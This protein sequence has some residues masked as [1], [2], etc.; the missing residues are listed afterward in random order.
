MSE[1]MRVGRQ[2]RDAAAARLR[3]AYA[4][5]YLD[6]SELERR[7]EEV[8]AAKTDHAL[9]RVTSD[10]PRPEYKTPLRRRGGFWVA[11]GGAGAAQVPISLSAIVGS[12]NGHPLGAIRPVLIALCLVACVAAVLIAG[13]NYPE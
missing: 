1:I 11:V 4:K 9:A 6:D 7:L 10:L 12:A 2:E 5:E 8:H 13:F 3:E